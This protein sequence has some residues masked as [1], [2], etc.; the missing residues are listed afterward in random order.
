MGY[1]PVELGAVGPP[2][3]DDSVAEL[4]QKSLLQRAGLERPQVR[5][6]KS[7]HIGPIIRQTSGESKPSTNRPTD[8][9]I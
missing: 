7:K 3:L 8:D 6:V 5:E 9:P 4:F 1:S 2:P